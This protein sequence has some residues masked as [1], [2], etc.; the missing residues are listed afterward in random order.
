VHEDAFEL[1]A[2]AR[3]KIEE[4]LISSP[5]NEPVLWG[6]IFE[7]LA[8]DFLASGWCDRDTV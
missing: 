3:V 1:I 6:I 5:T 8:A 2:D 7:L 4:M